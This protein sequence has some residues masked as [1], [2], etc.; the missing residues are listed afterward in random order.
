MTPLFALLGL[1][2]VDDMNPAI[3]RIRNIPQSPWFGVLKVMQDYISSTIGLRVSG[4]R[5]RVE[6]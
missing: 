6:G 3:P 2:T 4:F 1:P 5:I